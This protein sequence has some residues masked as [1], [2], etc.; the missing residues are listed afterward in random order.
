MTQSW[1][2]GASLAQAG[3]GQQGWLPVAAGA[4]G[5]LLLTWAGLGSCQAGMCGPKTGRALCSGVE[6]RQGRG[7]LGRQVSSLLTS[8]R[9]GFLPGRERFGRDGVDGCPALAQ[10]SFW[11][12]AFP[13]L[14][15]Q[16]PGTKI[17]L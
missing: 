9:S 16:L 5:H 8:A 14:V 13:L 3:G 12:G 2:S 4:W 17:L 6:R 7:S 11:R 1:V 15:C 10:L